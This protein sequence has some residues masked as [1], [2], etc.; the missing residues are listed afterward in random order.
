MSWQQ[1]KK[2]EQRQIS[3]TPYR[4]QTWSIRPRHLRNT[5]HQGNTPKKKEVGKSSSRAK[6]NTGLP[7]RDPVKKA[8]ISKS[9]PKVGIS[10]VRKKAALKNEVIPG[11]SAAKVRARRPVV[12][13]A[14]TVKSI[15]L[16]LLPKVFPWQV[17]SWRVGNHKRPHCHGDIWE[18]E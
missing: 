1:L 8:R 6:F 4:T 7:S 3:G 14:N 12:S 16:V 13:Y 10:H 18:M 17:P 11:G 9:T 2:E 15:W 5:E